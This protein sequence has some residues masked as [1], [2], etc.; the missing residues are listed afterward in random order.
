MLWSIYWCIHRLVM[1]LNM[2]FC[3]LQALSLLIAAQELGLVPICSSKM[4]S[5]R[6]IAEPIQWWDV[7]RRTNWPERDENISNIVFYNQRNSMMAMD[8]SDCEDSEHS[9]STPSIDGRSGKEVMRVRERSSWYLSNAEVQIS[10]WRIP[11]W[12]I[13]K[14]VLQ[15]L[16]TIC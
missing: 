9:D 12:Q 11:I 6:V 3:L 15:C 5:L 2:N 16:K 13:S 1:L 14:V 8:T 4:M 10:T 7:C